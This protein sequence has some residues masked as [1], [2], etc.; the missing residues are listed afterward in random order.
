M[1]TELQLSKCDSDRIWIALDYTWYIG[2][3]RSCIDPGAS[4]DA[5]GFTAGCWAEISVYNGKPAINV[6]C[7]FGLQWEI[8]YYC[9]CTKGQGRRGHRGGFREFLLDKA[10]VTASEIVEILRFEFARLHL[11]PCRLAHDLAILIFFFH[12]DDR[13][14]F[15]ASSTWTWARARAS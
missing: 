13:R 14:P 15:H 4:P 1:G 3:E 6:I 10:G 7:N 9:S 12:S 2:P 5:Q 11:S 8:F